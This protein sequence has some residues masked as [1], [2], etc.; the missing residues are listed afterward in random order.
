M[1]RGRMKGITVLSYDYPP[2]EGGIS[3][4]CAEIVK[5]FHAEN[6]DINAISIQR[7]VKGAAFAAPDVDE[8]R[9]S[10]KRGIGDLH[11]LW[12]L[13]TQYRQRIVIAG[14]WYPEGLLAALAGCKN[15]VVLV[16]GNEVMQGK[17]SLKNRLL[18][19]LRVFTLKRAKLVISN[20]EYTANLVRSQVPEAHVAVAKLGVDHMRFQP[21]TPEQKAQA[22]AKLGLREDQKVILTTSRVQSYKAH[23]T[24]LRGLSKT[25]NTLSA[26]ERDGLVYLVAGRGEHL[27]S[28][29]S[30]AIELGIENNVKWLGFVQ[31]SQ[32]PALYQSADLFVLCTRE[33]T[34]AKKVEGFGL[35]FLEAQACG[36]PVVGTA[37]GGIPDALCTQSGGW[38]IQ[39]DDDDHL[40]QILLALWQSPSA[41]IEAG[42]SA[43]L[44]V[45]REATWQH[46][47]QRVKA[48]L[49]SQFGEQA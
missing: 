1:S 5:V 12:T 25:L 48:C 27:P 6:A 15:L 36:V 43:R 46:Y 38:L 33:E 35:V 42:H 3:R 31:E 32:L 21:A 2:L 28:L 9:V 47:S 14:V 29:Q 30:L 8:V 44:R 17:P 20:S 37:Q 41:F 19:R 4:L 26:K 49:D 16:H 45:E 18:N 13:F 22:K 34:D 40:S 11:L 10:S 24:V 39:R 23:D 7:D